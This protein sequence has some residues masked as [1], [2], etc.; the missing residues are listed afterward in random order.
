MARFEILSAEE[1]EA[2]HK[3]WDPLRPRNITSTILA[4][5]GGDGCD[6]ADCNRDGSVA[7]DDVFKVMTSSGTTGQAV[8][9]ITLDV[10]TAKLQTRASTSNTYGWPTWS[11]NAVTSNHR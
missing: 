4:L 10:A 2:Y 1:L 6:N 5:S 9:R 11:A 3:D 8:S 7:D